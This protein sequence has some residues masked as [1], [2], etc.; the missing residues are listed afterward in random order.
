M[1]WLNRIFGA[2]VPAESRE[3]PDGCRLLREAFNSEGLGNVAEAEKLYRSVP[4]HSPAHA[5]AMFYLARLAVHDH[6]REEALALFQQAVDERPD[7]ALYR[8]A[9]GDALAR[10]RRFED[11][12]AAYSACR[13]LQAEETVMVANYAGALIELDRREEARIE[14]ERLVEL[15]PYAPEVHFNLGGIYREYCRTDEAI[16]CYSRAL[17]LDPSSSDTYSNLL[18]ELNTSSTLSA[19]AVFEEHRRFGEHF[20]LTKGC[21]SSQT[22]ASMSVTMALPNMPAIY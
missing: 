4:E 10:E 19:Q 11:A 21:G 6:R 8:L 20:A 15:A 16:A 5:Q 9:L 14:L 1:S 2:A 3:A 7:D 18:L 17:E 13:E 22:S 12:L